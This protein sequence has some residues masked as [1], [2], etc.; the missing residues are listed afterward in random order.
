MTGLTNAERAYC[1][2]CGHHIQTHGIGGCTAYIPPRIGGAGFCCPLSPADIVA[3]RE[4]AA[5]AEGRREV[6]AEVEALVSWCETDMIYKA[7]E[8]WGL[9]PERYL[10]RFRALVARLGGDES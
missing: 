5:R 1:P 8:E 4:A 2:R 7:P 3:A 10:S 9:L 6:L